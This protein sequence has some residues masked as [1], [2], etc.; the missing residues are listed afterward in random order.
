MPRVIY[1]K[2]RSS[3]LAALTVLV[4]WAWPLVLLWLNRHTN[5]DILLADA[6]FDPVTRS[7]PWKHS[8]LAENFAHGWLKMILVVL[9]VAIVATTVW[10]AVRPFARWNGEF[11]VR[12][13]VLAFSAGLVPFAIGAVKRFSPM[14]CPWDIDRYGGQ[15]PYF[16]LLDALP[17]GVAPGHCFPAGHASSALWLVAIAVFWL[18]HRPRTAGVVGSAMLLFSFALGWLQQLRGA[19]FLS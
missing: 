5:L 2:L 15:V 7:F 19:H 1:E 6:M 12:M 11:R 10:D 9:G 14:H 17:T 16:H 18:P 13:R 8:W 4:L 3:R